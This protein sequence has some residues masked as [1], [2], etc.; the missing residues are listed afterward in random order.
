MKKDNINTYILILVLAVVIFSFLTIY[1][2]G[3]HQSGSFSVSA[4]SAVIYQPEIKSFIY[5]KNADQRLPMA[6]TTKI[7]TALVALE[8]SDI[9]EL[10]AIDPDA[11]GVEGSS[12]YLKEGDVMTMEELL[13]ALLLQSANDAAAAIAYHVGGDLD[14]FSALMNKKAEGLQLTD[15]HFTN[16]HGLDN[17]DHYT[18]ATDLAIITAEALN[19]PI[20]KKIVST[21]KRTFVT[22]DRVRTYVNHNKLLNMYDGC[23]GIK[24]GF[25]KKSGRCL[26]GAAERD[27]LSFITVTLNAPNDW[28]DHKKMFDFGFESLEKISLAVEFD[29]VYKIPILD[30]KSNYVTVTN[31]DGASIIT[32]KD[33]HITNEN[34][35]LVRYCIAP[36]NR[37]DILG[38]IIYTI[39]GRETARVPLVAIDTVSK[40]ENNSLFDK[41]LSIFD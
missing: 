1:A 22:E 8:N 31:P 4:R 33:N 16:P 15:T 40:K 20:F 11:I 35:K 21:Y 30:G 2:F 39:D 13:Y 3:D 5:S 7:M 9:E 18:T 37:G 27:G 6:S 38:E 10:V 36:V 24:T 29:H 19:N 12:A 23:I 14:G 34:V 32:E 17:E 28:S 25:T 26:V 41:I